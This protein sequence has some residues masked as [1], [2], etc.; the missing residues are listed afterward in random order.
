MEITILGNKLRVEIILLCMIIGAF[1][2]CNLFCNCAGGAKEGF[3]VAQNLGG[4]ALN[5]SMGKDVKGSWSH[6]ADKYNMYARLESNKIGMVPPLPAGRLDM[7]GINVS[8]PDCCPSTYSS[9]T[10]CVCETP[11]QVRYLNSRGGNRTLTSM[12]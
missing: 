6:A 11:E 10:G 3:A 4:A 1:I 5:Y 7:L 2:A 12:F 8:S 9:S